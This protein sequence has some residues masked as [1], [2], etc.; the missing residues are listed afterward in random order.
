MILR[1]ESHLVR[2]FAAPIR[3]INI[4]ER[5]VPI[6]A[7]DE[8]FEALSLI[9]TQ[10]VEPFP[11]ILFGGEYWRGL[12]KWIKE[13]PLKKGALFESELA[14]FTS[15]NRPEDVVRFIKDFYHKAPNA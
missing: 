3:W 5:R 15:I 6:S 2:G 10:R 11:V 4:E 12:I 8:L 1:F 13:V 14:I 7:L 9:Q